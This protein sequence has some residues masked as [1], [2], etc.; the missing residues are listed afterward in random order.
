[1]SSTRAICLYFQVHQPYRIRKYRFF[2]IGN[3][4][5]YFDEFAN[6]SIMQKIAHK[7]YIP[8]NN[9]I[10]ELIKKHAGKFKVA[11][12]ISGVCL[13]QMKQY[14]PEALES[15]KRLAETGCVEFLSETYGHSLASLKNKD[16]FYAQVE[17]HKKLIQ[18]YF[19]QTPTVFR[20][21]ELIYSDQIGKMVADLG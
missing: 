6:K 8:A 2:D 12:S 1:M 16:E 18:E 20:N 13:E 17:L 11:Y 14:A 19:G 10:L 7:C 15:F 3:D 4:H 9:I 21:T 5:N